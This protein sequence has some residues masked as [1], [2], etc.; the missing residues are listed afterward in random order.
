MKPVSGWNQLVVQMDDCDNFQLNPVVASRKGN[1]QTAWDSVLRLDETEQEIV[2]Q[3]L[4]LTRAP[5]MLHALLVNDVALMVVI[6]PALVLFACRQF[7]D[8]C[9]IAERLNL[10]NVHPILTHP[11]LH[12][13][14]QPL[15]CVPDRVVIPLVLALKNVVPLVVILNVLILPPLLH[16][17]FAE[18]I[19]P[20]NVH[21]RTLNKLEIVWGIQIL[22][23][24]KMV[25]HLVLVIKNVVPLVVIQSALLL[26]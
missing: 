22:A 15:V 2:V 6:V 12:H 5:M 7:V 26:Y 19:N 21:H 14:T 4:Q 24:L 25:M 9:L 10:D 11:L 20:D 8:F 17:L 18:I 3:Q 16:H 1:A 13:V 23:A